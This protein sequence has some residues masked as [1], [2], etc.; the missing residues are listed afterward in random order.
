MFVLS[1]NDSNLN[2]T[3]WSLNFIF[4][5]Q[6]TTYEWDVWRSRS[7]GSEIPPADRFWPAGWGD[8][9]S[10]CCCSSSWSSCRYSSPR[11]ADMSSL[12]SWI[13]DRHHKNAVNT[14]SLMWP[15]KAGFF[16]HHVWSSPPVQSWALCACWAQWWCPAGWPGCGLEELAWRWGWRRTEWPLDRCWTDGVD[17]ESP[18]AHPPLG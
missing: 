15:V 7:R 5:L 9:C 14:N 10:S 4:T 16:E 13:S 1:L 18:E 12:L 8:R 17:L 11:D 6:L 2:L 3:E